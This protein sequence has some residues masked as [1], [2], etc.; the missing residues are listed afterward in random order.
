MQNAES[1]WDFEGA[2]IRF[3]NLL[4]RFGPKRASSQSTARMADGKESM[5]F[6]SGAGVYPVWLHL[7][8][9]SVA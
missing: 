8:S 3:A 6:L 7:F 2:P 9:L 1:L 4:R 5:H